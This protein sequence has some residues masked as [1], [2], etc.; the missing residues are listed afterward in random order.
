VTDDRVRAALRDLHAHDRPPG[1]DA[2]VAAARARTRRR[3][4]VPAL[5][6][7]V[8]A[9]AVIIFIALRPASEPELAADGVGMTST[10]LR[11]P[12]DSLLDVPGADLLASIP[13]LDQGAL[14]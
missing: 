8:A 13:R 4:L 3:W 2:T 12:T 11:L 7:A 1:F 6:V 14:P 9:A 5:G 10:S